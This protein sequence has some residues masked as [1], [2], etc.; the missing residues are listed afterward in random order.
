MHADMIANII[1][2]RGRKLTVYQR[3]LRWVLDDTGMVTNSEKR[4]N[5]SEIMLLREGPNL[6]FKHM[7]QPKQEIGLE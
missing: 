4:Q 7:Y 2:R 1:P 6:K 3:I 5:G